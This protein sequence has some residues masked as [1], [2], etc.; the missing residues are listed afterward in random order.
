MKVIG[1]IPSRLKSTR[2]PNK[3]LVDIEG[4]PMIVHVFKRVQLCP[5]LDEVF[6]A[7]DSD[8]IYETVCNYGGQAIM[9]SPKQD[10]GT[11]RI[12]E[13]ASNMAVDIVV[14]IQ[15]DEPLLNP[16]DI[17]KLVEAI[18]ADSSIESATLVCKS[19]E[20]N[21]VTE[22]K[23]VLDMNNDILYMSRADIPSSAR[24]SVDVL[25][26][27]YCIVAFRTAFLQKFVS[28]PVSTLE[29][30]EYIEYLRILEHGYKIRGVVVEEYTTSVDTPQDLEVVKKMMNKDKIKFRYL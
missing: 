27:L 9:T 18:T 6:V 1:L 5:L 28:W 24:S 12:A 26:K 22:C 3:A 7:T 10:C 21:N 13:A 15:G 4:L 25:H 2:F 11:E 8:E 29:E 19:P 17:D 14:N 23:V 30:I 20:F 16:D